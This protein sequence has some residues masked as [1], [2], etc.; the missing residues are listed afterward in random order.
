M[1]TIGA[2]AV[3]AIIALIRLDR[4]R[5]LAA[6]AVLV[7]ANVATRLLKEHLLVRPD[8]GVDE[9]GPVTLNSLPS[10]HATAAFSAVAALLLV[11]P[12]AWRGSV[13]LLGGGFA[14]LT[15][16]RRLR[17]TSPASWC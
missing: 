15:A 7:T 4:I 13:A 9:V 1:R 14:T 2:V 16:L 6:I 5:G 11:L 12:A 3:V 17:R 10:G 8:L